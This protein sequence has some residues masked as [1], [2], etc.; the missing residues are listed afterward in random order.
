[1]LLVDP[2]RITCDNTTIPLQCDDKEA[3]LFLVAT[4]YTFSYQVPQAVESALG[5]IFSL[6]RLPEPVTLTPGHKAINKR[7]LLLLV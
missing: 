3:P 4:Y 6:L 7:L 1:M 5:L 2:L